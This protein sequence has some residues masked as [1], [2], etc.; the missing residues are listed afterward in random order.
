[1]WLC[2]VHVHL[3]DESWGCNCVHR[4]TQQGLGACRQGGEAQSD[5]L[6]SSLLS[7]HVVLACCTPNLPTTDDM[8]LGK[9][10]QVSE[11]RRGPSSCSYMHRGRAN[12]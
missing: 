11:A 1:M 3:H 9:T 5:L 7:T 2:N 6:T 4:M 8:G 12:E 10:V